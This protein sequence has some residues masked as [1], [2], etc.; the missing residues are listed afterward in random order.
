ML[1]IY[2]SCVIVALIITV[3]FCGPQ[4]VSI[5]ECYI[6]TRNLDRLAAIKAVIRDADEEGLA[7]LISKI[8]LLDISTLRFVSDALEACSAPKDNGVFTNSLMAQLHKSCQDLLQERENRSKSLSL[9]SARK[10][11]KKI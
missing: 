2:I 9:A 1:S 10:R 5:L 7:L 8:P 3:S 6:E 11:L 4:L